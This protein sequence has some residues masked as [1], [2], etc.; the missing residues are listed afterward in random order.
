MEVDTV[1]V[2]MV[3]SDNNYYKNFPSA[4]NSYNMGAFLIDTSASNRTVSI[5]NLPAPRPR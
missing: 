4:K 3:Y 2:F 5:G 1:T